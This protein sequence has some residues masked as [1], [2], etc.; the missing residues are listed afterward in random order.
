[1]IS[2][3]ELA[4]QI[5]DLMLDVFCRLDESVT[6]VRQTCSPEEADAYSKAVGRIAGPNVM[7]MEPIYER[8]PA[9]KPLNWDD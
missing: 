9:L 2:N 5:S 7:L 4:K 1:M 3:G 8:H 6:T